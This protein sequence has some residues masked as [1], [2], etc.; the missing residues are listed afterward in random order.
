M[1]SLRREVDRLGRT[2][3]RG[4]GG[5]FVVAPAIV[6]SVFYDYVGRL[7]SAATGRYVK[8][9]PLLARV[10]VEEEVKNF[11]FCFVK[12][13]HTRRGQNRFN[14]WEESSVDVWLEFVVPEGKLD[15][16]PGDSEIISKIEGFLGG[17]LHSWIL[18]LSQVKHVWGVEKRETDESATWPYGSVS[19]WRM[20]D[21]GEKLI[22]EERVYVG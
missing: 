13:F 8:P 10:P 18:S 16:V 6:P 19:A 7:H 4:S 9:L 12:G 11:Y 22:G 15:E 20:P 1:S 2:H 5:R 17:H 14:R 3:Y 21:Y